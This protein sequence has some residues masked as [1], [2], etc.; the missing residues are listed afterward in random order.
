MN[1]SEQGLVIVDDGEYYIELNINYD[2]TIAPGF[3]Q[4]RCCFGVTT[5]GGY[6]C[7]GSFERDARGVWQASID[8]PYDERTGGDSHAS[9]TAWTPSSHSGAGGTR[10]FPGTRIG[11]GSSF[12]QSITAARQKASGRGRACHHR[13]FVLRLGARYGSMPVVSGVRL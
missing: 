7:I 4:R 2:A 12:A 9:P 11:D 8:A 1:S 3:L 13:A 6:D 10:R 5:P